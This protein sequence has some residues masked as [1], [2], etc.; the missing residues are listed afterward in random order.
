MEMW[1]EKKDTYA[2]TEKKTAD[3]D[4]PF[5][6]AYNCNIALRE[7]GV[8][9]SPV[10]ARPDRGKTTVGIVG[11]L[12]EEAYIDG[13]AVF[14][15]VRAWK[16]VVSSTADGDMPV[17]SALASSCEGC[18]GKRDLADSL[19]LDKTPRVQPSTGRPVRL[20]TFLV[21]WIRSS[22]YA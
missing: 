7:L 17:T 21:G 4:L 22:Q 18:Q 9:P 3:P 14:D 2:A 20:N 13:D 16:E 5:P 10:T 15:V 19:W 1:K 12:I 8:C 6:T 11:G